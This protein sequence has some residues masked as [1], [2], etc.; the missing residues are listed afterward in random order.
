MIAR[1]VIALATVSLLLCLTFGQAQAKSPS[2]VITGGDLGPYAMHFTFPDHGPLIRSVAGAPAVSHGEGLAY[3][4]HDG[5]VIYDYVIGERGPSYRY[6]PAQGIV[7]DV[8][9]GVVYTLPLERAR[10]LDAIVANALSERLNDTLERG[11]LAA[12]LRAS[13]LSEAHMWL[14]PENW[15]RSTEVAMHCPCEIPRMSTERW[16]MQDLQQTLQGAPQAPTPNELP[17][18]R[19]MISFAGESGYGAFAHY[20]FPRGGAPGRLWVWPS[21]DYPLNNPYLETTQ[22]FDAVISAALPQGTGLQPAAS[23]TTMLP[24]NVQT[25]PAAAGAIALGF[26]AAA[27][28]GVSALSRRLRIA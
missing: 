21:F 23:R 3:D 18:L 17:D 9:A 13:Q 12:V 25:T 2:Y 11:V 27:L 14:A 19:I 26:A 22:G 4:I 8:R 16:I 15:E 5:D 1:T 7:E 24:Q 10:E 28:V 6:H 20:R